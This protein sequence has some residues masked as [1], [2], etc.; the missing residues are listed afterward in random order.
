MRKSSRTS[1]YVQ[2]VYTNWWDTWFKLVFPLLMPTTK[3]KEE[4][5]Y[6][7]AGDICLINFPG[8]RKDCYKLCKIVDLLPDVNGLV[9]TVKIQHRRADKRHEIREYR[10]CDRPLRLY[11]FKGSGNSWPLPTMRLQVIRQKTKGKG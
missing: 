3:W 1:A 2:A 11:Q 5:K 10:K 7:K 9:R 6:M 8:I 4:E